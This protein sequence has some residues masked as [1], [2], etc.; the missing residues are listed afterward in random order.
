[1]YDAVAQ[2][3]DDLARALTIAGKQDQD[4]ETD[5]VKALAKAGRQFETANEIS[6]AFGR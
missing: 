4:A 6:R 5:Q 2:V 3:S 1:V